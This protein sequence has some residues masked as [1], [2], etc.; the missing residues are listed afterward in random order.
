[1]DKVNKRKIMNSLSFEYGIVVNRI[2]YN[3]ALDLVF[4]EIIGSYQLFVKII[5]TK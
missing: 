1:M 2:L 3:R 4:E 5:K